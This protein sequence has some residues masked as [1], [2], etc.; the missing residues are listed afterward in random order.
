MQDFDKITIQE[1]SKEDMLL[2]IRALEYTGTHTKVQ[3]FLDLRDSF[4]DELSSLSEIP[5]KD[6]LDFLKKETL[7]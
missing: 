3:D 2:I 7:S 5:K 4:I 6:F 1:M